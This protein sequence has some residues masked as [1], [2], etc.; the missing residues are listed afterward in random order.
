VRP[1]YL[2]ECYCPDPGRGGPV[3]AVQRVVSAARAL[4]MEGHDIEYL[5]GM[6]LPSDDVVFYRFAGLDVNDVVAVCR[7]AGI[8]VT[9]VTAYTEIEDRTGADPA[10]AASSV[11]GPGEV[12]P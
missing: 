11:S 12:E 2:V 1:T 10:A 7:A 5:D 4:R 9:R 3:V 8:P 6:V